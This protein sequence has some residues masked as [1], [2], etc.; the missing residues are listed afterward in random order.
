MSTAAGVLA[1]VCARV[2]SRGVQGKNFRQLNGKALIMH[3]IQH[4]LESVMVNH[5]AAVTNKG[6]IRPEGVMRIERPAALERPDAQKWEV[7]R[8]AVREFEQRTGLAVEVVVGVPG[9]V[10]VGSWVAER[11]G[12]G[13]SVAVGSVVGAGSAVEHAARRRPAATSPPKNRTFRTAPLLH[14]AAMPQAE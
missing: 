9:G 11:E 4:A 1:L 14:F 6:F 2:N 7:W 10:G 5:V 3:S 12:T 13:D 8:H